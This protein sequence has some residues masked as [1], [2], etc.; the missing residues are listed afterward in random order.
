MLWYN[1]ITLRDI[2]KLVVDRVGRV[3]LLVGCLRAN[4]RVF[5][6]GKCANV[7]TVVTVVVV[8]VAQAIDGFLVVVALLVSKGEEIRKGWRD[9]PVF[10]PVFDVGVGLVIHDRF[11]IKRGVEEVKTLLAR[12]R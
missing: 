3:F 10:R 11:R 8:A 6:L 12:L 7:V 1:S 5:L 4:A 9:R 2:E